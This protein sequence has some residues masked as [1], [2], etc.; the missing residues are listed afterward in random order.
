MNDEELI[1][2]IDTLF[3]SLLLSEKH[4]GEI[5]YLK[6]VLSISRSQIY[7]TWLLWDAK[8]RTY[9]N[10]VYSSDALRLVMHLHNYLEG[11]WHKKRQTIVLDYLQRVKAKKICDIGFGTPQK[12]VQRFLESQ[13]TEIF[14]MDFEE[15]SLSFAEKVLDYW[16]QNWRK[17]V[18]LGLFDMNTDELPKGFDSYLFQDSIEHADDPSEALHR[19]V[20]QMPKGTNV[21]FSLPIEIEN[22]VPEH[23]I[24]WKNEEEIVAWLERAGLSAISHETILMDKNVDLFCLSLHPDFR[25]VVLE[26]RK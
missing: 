23:H 10:E 18:T 7:A 4:R 3:E 20:E 8:K 25:E 5:E 26:A 19:F 1:R 11:S 9:S 2:K 16:S 14:L 24:Y 6:K 12:Y 22:P 17:N 15:S 21:I 13:E